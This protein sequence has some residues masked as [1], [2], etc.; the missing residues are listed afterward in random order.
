MGGGVLHQIVTRLIIF[1][2]KAS[3]C[4]PVRLRP[5]L[6]GICATPLLYILA[7]YK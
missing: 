2:L 1:A 7:I 4:A 5:P 3:L 6:L